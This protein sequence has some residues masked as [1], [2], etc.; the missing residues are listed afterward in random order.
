M[1][2]YTVGLGGSRPLVFPLTIQ[3]PGNR[4]QTPQTPVGVGRQ[5]LVKLA[6][7]DKEVYYFILVTTPREREQVFVYTSTQLPFQYVH[8]LAF[9]V[10]MSNLLLSIKCGVAIGKGL[11]PDSPIEYVNPL[12]EAFQV[13]FV[14]FSYHAFLRLCDDLSNPFG[15]KLFGSNCSTSPCQPAS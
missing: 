7:N 14:P 11:R 5:V 12:V 4:P 9:T 13:F 1:V 3:G 10:I 15:E 8:L 6:P 2:Y